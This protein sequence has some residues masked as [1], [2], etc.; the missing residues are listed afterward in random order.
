MVNG[1][2]KVLTLTP[3]VLLTNIDINLTR[4]NDRKL[5]T[6]GPSSIK[7][8]GLFLL[9]IQSTI[10]LISREILFITRWSFFSKEI[11]VNVFPPDPAW[12][13]QVDDAVPAF[14]EQVTSSNTGHRGRHLL[15]SLRGG[16][17]LLEGGWGLRRQQH[18]LGIVDTAPAT[19]PVVVGVRPSEEDFRFRTRLS[20]SVFLWL[21]RHGPTTGASADAVDDGEQDEDEEGDQG[22]DVGEDVPA[23][24]VAETDVVLQLLLFAFLPPT[25]SGNG[26]E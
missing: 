16:R 14:A 21:F 6:I 4:I 26:A 12:L 1:S 17:L 10:K 24:H 23:F 18:Q 20:T 15:L 3:V 8:A 13:V 2:K 5:Y 9:E 19:M 25:P 11:T 7:A 22:D